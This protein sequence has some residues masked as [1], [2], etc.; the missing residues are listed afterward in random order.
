MYKLFPCYSIK[1][2][3]SVQLG[4]I[5][6]G[7][8]A[9]LCCIPILLFA[10][11]LSQGFAKFLRETELD[12][13]HLTTQV[14]CA[15]PESLSGV[16]VLSID[17]R[18]CQEIFGGFALL[19]TLLLTLA[20]TIIPLLK[21]LYGWDLWYCIQILWTGHR[22]HTPANG[23]MTDDQYDAFVVFDTSN[24]AV[25]DWIYKEMIVRLENRGRWR[26][27]LCLEERDWLPGVSCIENL[28]KAVYSSRKTVFV[29]TSPSGYSQSS[30]VVRQAFLLVQQRLLDEKVDVAVLVLLD[31]LFPKFK[32]LQ[33]RKRLCKKS[34]LSWPKN[35]R[36]QPLFWNNL[37]VAL[38]SDNVK[39]YNKNVTESF[40]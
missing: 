14:H 39:A 31:F 30:G 16:N 27:R 33:M 24:K 11:A 37:R 15:Y 18:S 5:K 28:H 12:I 22:G 4:R 3:L 13:P 19:C 21:H 26:F 8:P 32:Y 25:R 35:P 20:A 23:N 36:V 6:I 40:F 2:I 34:V 38:V 7:P 1:V 29:L 10:V 9:N 17:L